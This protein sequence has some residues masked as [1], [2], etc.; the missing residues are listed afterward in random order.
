MRLGNQYTYTMAH[1]PHFGL[2]AEESAGA[3]TGDRIEKTVTVGVPRVLMP[4]RTPLE[5]RPCD[6]E[7]LLPEGHRARV[8]W[9][10]VE[11]AD[12]SALYAG[13]KA[14]AGAVAVRPSRRRWCLPY[15][16]MPP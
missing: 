16:Y 13:I 15:G 14:V 6:L 5:L 8:V 12:L 2:F 1:E 7:S 3:L 4:N 9:A 11:Q 10:Y